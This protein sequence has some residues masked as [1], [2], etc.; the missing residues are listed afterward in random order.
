MRD[1]QKD[2]AEKLTEVVRKRTELERELEDFRR[3]VL[4]IR[5]SI[6]WSIS[7]SA[8]FLLSRGLR[9]THVLRAFAAARS[10]SDGLMRTGM[11]AGG[12]AAPLA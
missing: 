1:R 12:E 3:T 5:S 9:M 10:A 6:R 4:L 7:A 11:I 8:S 2:V